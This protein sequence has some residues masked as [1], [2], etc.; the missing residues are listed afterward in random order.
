MIKSLFCLAFAL[1]PFFKIQA[2]DQELAI[3]N[4]YF[5]KGNYEK[6]KEIYEKF[7]KDK[8]DIR[9]VSTNYLTLLKITRDFNTA[10]KFLQ[11]SIRLFPDN[12]QYAA[13]LASIYNDAGN[14]SKKDK[15]LEKLIRNAKE[16]PFQISLLA[17]YLVNEQL[18]DDA[19]NFF[20]E[21]R[22][23]RSN[24]SLHS[25]ELAAIYRMKN[26]NPAMIEEYLNYASDDPN[27]LNYVKNLLQ[28]FIQEDEQ[29]TKLQTTLIKKAQE[30]PNDVKYP[31]LIIWIELQRKNFYDAFI[32][33]RAIDKRNLSPGDRT[34]QIGK[35]AL[36][37]KSYEDA[38][39]IF[40]Y[41][42]SQYETGRN[43]SMA[44]KLWMQ[45][46]E[47]K[48]KNT[49]P[50][51]KEEI[52]SL[53]K[54][55]FLLYQELR[56]SQIAYNAYRSKAL[57]HAFYLGEFE[58][59]TSILSQLIEDRGIG[60]LL[61]SQ[62]KL[63]LGDIY[64]LKG[65]P[66]ESTLLYSQV[67]KENQNHQLSYDAKLKNARLNYYTGN[68]LLAK[69]HLDILKKNTTRDI[70]NDAISLGMLIADNTVLDTTDQV[71]QR[72]ADIE[73]L[74]FQN[75]KTEA[76]SN[77]EEMLQTYQYHSIAD[78]V[79]WLLSKLE[80]ESGNYQK[81]IHYLDQVL[82]TYKYDILS[83]DAAFKKAEIYDYYLKDT[84]N[85]KQLYQE[86]MKEY[87]GSV[88]VAEARKRFRFIR[89]D[90]VK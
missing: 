19:I 45:S 12:M 75:K 66:W 30:Y 69:G 24:P 78:E 17:Q 53:S 18:Y 90:L 52:R 15:F 21:S 54:E 89:G 46:R 79:Y 84:E 67:E 23:L 83:D 87:P 11:R 38:A 81:A 2:Q 5:Q 62:V 25:L 51:D 39:E 14:L 42:A 88:Y 86:F 49:F 43:Y 4:E 60:K 22:V 41:V 9:L 40:A 72:F 13:N 68:F 58:T 73:L 20:L 33:A 55:Y 77:L 57:L 76:K 47:E 50:I 31:E 3:A 6:A 29:L 56:P 7:L 82:T 32:Q 8:D 48:I 16:N 1:L 65:E 59:A 10:E 71:M 63:D 74:I 28:S 35:I 37:N 64:L 70:S 36:D 85:A 27:R 34:M 44:K 80:L 26:D 61:K